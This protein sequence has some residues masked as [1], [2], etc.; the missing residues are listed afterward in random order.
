MLSAFALY[1]LRVGALLAAFYLLFKLLLSRETLHR[2]NR[3]VVLS[4]LVLSFVLP[5]CVVT[6]RQE[7]PFV[8]QE[9]IVESM[10]H[11]EFEAVAVATPFPWEQVLGVLFVVG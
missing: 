9:P 2:L 5:F 10:Q 3:V 1:T 8:E 6:I 11:V 7:I 4:V